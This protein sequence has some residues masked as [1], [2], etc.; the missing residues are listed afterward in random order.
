MHLYPAVSHFIVLWYK[1]SPQH[2][3]LRQPQSV[4]LP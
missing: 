3:V 1:Y 2:P 4:F